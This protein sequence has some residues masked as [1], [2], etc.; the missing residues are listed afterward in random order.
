MK[1]I[2]DKLWNINFT[3]KKSV[4]VNNMITVYA[5]VPVCNWYIHTYLSGKVFC[6]CKFMSC[7]IKFK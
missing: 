3:L 6:L 4:I 2:F 7:N 1:I 5:Y